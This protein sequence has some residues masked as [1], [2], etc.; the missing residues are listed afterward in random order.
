MQVADRLDAEGRVA[1]GQ[2]RIGER[3]RARHLGEAGVEDIDDAVVEVGRVQKVGATLGGMRQAL[4]DRAVGRAVD[5][6][7]RVVEI[8]VRRPAGDRAAFAGEDEGTRTGQ[9]VLGHREGRRGVEDDA[10]GSA[11][12]ACARRNRDDQRL[13][14]TVAVVKGRGRR[15]GV[16]HPDEALRIEGDAPGVDQIRI[17]V[18]AAAAVGVLHARSTDN[19][20]NLRRIGGDDGAGTRCRPGSAGTARGAPRSVP[21]PPHRAFR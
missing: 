14:H 11:A 4:V 8:D 9:P 16:G 5:H 3:A 19:G 12:P 21:F 6:E 20:R 15:A 2:V 1:G 17:D 18:S 10:V 13:R 7:D